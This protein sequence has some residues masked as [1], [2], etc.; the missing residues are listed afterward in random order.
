MRCCKAILI[1]LVSTSL[2][3]ACGLKG[4]LYLPEDEE[5]TQAA[6]ELTSESEMQ[7]EEKEETGDEDTGGSL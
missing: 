2:L 7:M 6:A 3:T 1:L 4:A 5:T